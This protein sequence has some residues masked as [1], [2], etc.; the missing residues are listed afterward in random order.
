MRQHGAPYRLAASRNLP[1]GPSMCSAYWSKLRTPR[2]RVRM[3]QHFSGASC[4]PGRLTNDLH[5]HVLG[6]E[7]CCPNGRILRGVV[8]ILY[9]A[10][11]VVI[12]TLGQAVRAD[13]PRHT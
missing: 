2:M 5:P 10:V 8:T 13:I 1:D 3:M 9:N 11:A 7:L 4:G 12:S 6:V